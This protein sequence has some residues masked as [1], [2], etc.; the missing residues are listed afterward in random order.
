M[1][2]TIV[3]VIVYNVNVIN[4]DN[5]IS[6]KTFK[7]S[8]AINHQCYSQDYPGQLSKQYGLSVEY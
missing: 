1:S 8:S 2:K 4:I 7:Q 6:G 5:A 3:W